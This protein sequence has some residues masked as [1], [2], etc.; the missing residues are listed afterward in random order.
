MSDSSENERT[1]PGE[2]PADNLLVPQP[3]SEVT[4]QKTLPCGFQLPLF[5]FQAKATS[6]Y[7]EGLAVPT[8]TALNIWFN[9]AKVLPQLE[10]AFLTWELFMEP[11]VLG[12]TSCVVSSSK[13]L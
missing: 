10:I 7:E 9:S 4:T 2:I 11:G 1:L 12:D 3:A 6:L 5:P 8:K 13:L